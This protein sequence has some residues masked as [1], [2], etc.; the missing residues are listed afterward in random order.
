MRPRISDFCGGLSKART[1]LHEMTHTQIIASTVDKNDGGKYV[2]VY[3]DLMKL[4]A[5][6]SIKHAEVYAAFAAGKQ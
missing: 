1:F 3:D 4:T 6:E 2:K 5:Q